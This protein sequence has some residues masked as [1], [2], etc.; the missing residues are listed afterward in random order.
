VRRTGLGYAGSGGRRAM[1][2]GRGLGVSR[3][4]LKALARDSSPRCRGRWCR[5]ARDQPAGGGPAASWLGGWPRD[6]AARRVLGCAPARADHRR[7]V[8]DA[9]PAAGGPGHCCG[10]LPRLARYCPRHASGGSVIP[11]DYTVTWSASR[12]SIAGMARPSA[13]GKTSVTWRNQRALAGRGCVWSQVTTRG[14]DLRSAYGADSEETLPARGHGEKIM[15]LPVSE[16][17]ALDAIEKQLTAEDPRLSLDL[18]AFT[19]VTSRAGIPI[20]ERLDASATAVASNRTRT[21][22][23][24]RRIILRLVM[25]LFAG[26]LLAPGT[27]AAL[28]ANHPSRCPPPTKPLSTI[29]HPRAFGSSGRALPPGSGNRPGKAVSQLPANRACPRPSS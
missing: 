24:R 23:R 3:N 19:S 20:T 14:V 16:Q 1:P 29:E 11:R 28:S 25:L 7:H 2:V 22:I 4:K 13:V 21:E 18:A 26:A 15:A 9:V 5:T 10:G 12:W 6:H 17:L 27:V 8:G